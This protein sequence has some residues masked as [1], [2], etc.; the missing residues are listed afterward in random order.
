MLVA[1]GCLMTTAEPAAAES[2]SKAAKA[3]KLIQAAFRPDPQY[4]AKY[5]AQ[6]QVDIYGAKSAVEPPRPPI[7]LGRQQYTSGAYDE[8]STLLGQLNPLLPGLA[9][10]GLSLIH[11]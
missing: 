2:S 9:I 11:I 10:Y 5:N 6:T 7:E 3:D 1:G 4:D 8:S